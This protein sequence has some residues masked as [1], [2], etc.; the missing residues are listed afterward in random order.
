[1]F[2]VLLVGTFFTVCSNAQQNFTIEEA[3]LKG[4]SDLA[5]KRLKQLTFSKV[6]GTVSYIDIQD[7]LQQLTLVSADGKKS[8]FLTLSDLN[9]CLSDLGKEK[10]KSFP[11]IEWVSADAFQFLLDKKYL[12]YSSSSKKLEPSS[13]T[14]IPALENVEIASNGAIY[15]STKNYNLMLNVNGTEKAITTD[16]NI[17]LVYGHAVHR[18]EFGIDK[19]IFFSPKSSF[20]AFY[21]MDQSMVTDYPIID[22]SKKP[23]ISSSLKYP[24]A[25][26]KSHHVKIGIYNISNDKTIY[27]NIDGDPEQYL[28]NIAWSADESKIYVAIVNRAQNLMKLNEYDVATGQFLKNL[29][30]ERDE[31]YIEPLNPLLIV[32]NNPKQFIW[33]SNRDGFKHLYLY[34]FNGKLLRQ[35][36]SGKW[37]ITSL[38]GFDK[39]G[40]NFFF[41]A[42]LSSP[43]NQDFCMVNLKT[44]KITKLSNEDGFHTALLDE[45]GMYFIDNFS[46]TSTPRKSE[47]VGVQNKKKCTLLNAPNPISR[48]KLGKLKLFS[49]QNKEN[50][51]LY[52]RMFLPIDFDST[53]KY[54]A[55]VYLYNGPHSQLVTNSWLAGADLWYHYMAQKGF[56][57]F[58]LDGRGT[59]NRGKLFQQAIHRQLGNVEMEDQMVGVDFLKKLGYVDENRL[60]VHGWSFGGFLTTSLMTRYPGVFKTGVAG[61]PVID[62]SIYEIMY[63]ERYMDS[64]VENMDGYKRNNLLNNIQN[65]Q[66]KLM[67]IHGTD[68]D[69]VVWQHSIMLLSKAVEKGV[70][71]DYYVYPGHQ[72]NV[73]GK[74]RAHLMEKISNYFIENL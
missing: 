51:D 71:L 10:L 52:C 70:Q 33:Q 35:L 49:I 50:T 46:N 20:V 26:D 65:L 16:G 53:K 42:N 55:I 37:E 27:L 1:M 58:T 69:V 48:Y 66:G 57:I 23:A 64:P 28:T 40:E 68:D 56:I 8:I 15:A 38:N 54:P 24:F 11:Y 3:I 34:D 31:K 5:P 6:P 9:K 19:G 22:W 17:N 4:R 29:F 21:R 72:H 74:D 30:E 39:S 2:L 32:K 45:D 14:P 62:W 73:L 67:L 25:G 12:V 18:N 47:L 13:K 36:T 61:G 7:T 59:D 63:T 43:V 60:G 41:H 44:A